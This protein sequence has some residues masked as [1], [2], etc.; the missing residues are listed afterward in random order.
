MVVRKS[1]ICLLKEDNQIK[2]VHEKKKK[3]TAVLI[4]A[5]RSFHYMIT[6]LVS[7]V[8]NSVEDAKRIKFV[9]LVFPYV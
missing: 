5:M 9:L 6:S 1:I 8:V 4:R 7:P 2:I 3:K